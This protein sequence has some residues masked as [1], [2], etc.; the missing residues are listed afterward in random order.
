MK[1]DVWNSLREME[2]TEED[3]SGT[4]CWGNYPS[5]NKGLKTGIQPFLGKKHTEET[6][7]LMSLAKKGKKNSPEHCDNMAKAFAR[8]YKLTFADGREL[9]ITNMRKFCRESK[10]HTAHLRG[11]MKGLRGRHFDIVAVEELAATP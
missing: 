5:W 8:T 7:R 1:E 2:W 9:I 6:K 4:L 10:Y 11:V 3:Y